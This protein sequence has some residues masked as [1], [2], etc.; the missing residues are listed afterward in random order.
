TAAVFVAGTAGVRLNLTASVPIGLYFVS[1][2]PESRFVEFCPPDPFGSLSIDRGYRAQSTACPDGG[3]PLLKPVI[4]REGD[5][6][7]V[8]SNGISVNGS[9]VWNTAAKTHD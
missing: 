4:A 2:S 3:E 8:S 5:L 9:L 6:V 7:E 1:S